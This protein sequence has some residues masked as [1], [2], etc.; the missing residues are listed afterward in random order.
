MRA[1]TIGRLSSR[2]LSL[3]FAALAAA[4]MLAACGGGGDEDGTNTT[5][6][7][8]RNTTTAGVQ[9]T[10]QPTDSGGIENQTF[11]IGEHFFH[12]GFRVDVTE[13]EIVTTEATLGRDASTSLILT[14]TLENRGDDTGYFGPD[15]AISTANNSYSQSFASNNDDTPG[16]LKT[17]ATFDF[18]IDEN[19]DLATAELI[20]GRS[21]E[22]RARIPLSGGGDAVRLEPS[23]PAITGVLSM[24]LI[25]LEFTSATLAYDLPNRH[26]QMDEGKQALTLY[27][28]AVSRKGGNWNIFPDN[29]VLVLPDGTSLAA[30]DA[31]AYGLP[32]SDEGS[33][34]PD[35]W[36]R[37]V[38][39]ESLSGDLAIV[40]TPG[41]W[42]LA[43]DG[44]TE[45]TFEFTLA[46]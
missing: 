45:G 46:P 44:V 37:F 34:T 9:G 15:L 36:V 2:G 12:S 5:A 28:D 14:A 29:L 25:D 39:D 20:V 13:G 17:Q 30:D 38:V 19:F 43:D 35:Q 22:S 6:A 42:F 26:R 24:P 11:T 41:Q 23:E 3:A 32:G 27:F 18:R 33:T 40:L 4:L 10:S 31:D 7:P 21:D 16:G 1:A 8:G